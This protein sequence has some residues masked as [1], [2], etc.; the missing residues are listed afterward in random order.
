MGMILIN[1]KQIK[2]SFTLV[3]YFSIIFLLSIPSSLLL[4]I[5][6]LLYENKTEFEEK[7][8]LLLSMAYNGSNTFTLKFFPKFLLITE[9]FLPLL[10]YLDYLI[11]FHYPFNIEKFMS[12]CKRIQNLDVEQF[13]GR[14]HCELARIVSCGHI[15]QQQGLQ[16]HHHWP[17]LQTIVALATTASSCFEISF[18]VPV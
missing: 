12:C 11:V 14:S 1:H 4:N 15:L 8:T 7:N 18:Q 9:E 17:L 6:T 3:H 16:D 10:L 2:F 13:G 5:K